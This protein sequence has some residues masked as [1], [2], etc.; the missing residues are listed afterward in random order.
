MP[1]HVGIPFAGKTNSSPSNA[2]SD[3]GS[4]HTMKSA[5]IILAFSVVVSTV[6]V[7]DWISRIPTT[8]SETSAVEPTGGPLS[9][10][11]IHIG[12]IP[13]RDIFAQRRR[14]LAL[15]KYA[16]RNLNQTVDLMTAN[17][18]LGVLAD[19]ESNRLDAAFLGSLVAVLAMDRDNAMVSIKP[20]SPNGVSTYRGVIFVRDDSPLQNLNDLRGETIAMVRSTTAGD[21]YPIYELKRNNLLHVEDQ[22]KILWVGT[23]DAVIRTVV[24]GNCDVGAAK[25]LRLDAYSA[26]P[27]AVA[28]RR[29]AV[30]PPVPNNALVLSS[31][32]AGTRT[33][34]ALTEL[35]LSMH[36]LSGGKK[37]LAELGIRQFTP[38]SPLEYQ[39]IMEMIDFLGDDWSALGIDGQE[40]A[41]FRRRFFPDENENNNT[42]REKRP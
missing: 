5:W 3:M 42:N 17:T 6:V 33:G 13:E 25:D 8:G 15:A 20:M 29:L 11:V 10:E 41:T 4:K 9:T 34:I 35:L 31:K 28:I 24:E 7:L 27:D 22:P 21:L 32:S 16:E 37:V 36:E 14:Y 23:H 12:I 2:L 19:F 38:C 30:G 1:G 26:A 40:P 39:P 18:Y